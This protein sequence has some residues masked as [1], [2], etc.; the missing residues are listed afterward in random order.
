LE[1]ITLACNED[2]NAFWNLLT[3]AKIQKALGDKAGAT[4]TSALSRAAAEKA[5]NSAYVKM[6]DELM[7][8]LK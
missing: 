3:K 1:W 2:T 7:K 5:G 6:N 8:T 4:A